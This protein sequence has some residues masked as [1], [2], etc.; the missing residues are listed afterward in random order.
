ML[1]E[2]IALILQF[3]AIDDTLLIPFYAVS[4]RYT[5]VFSPFLNFLPF[6]LAGAIL[7]LKKEIYFLFVH[8]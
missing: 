6:P 2:V 3:M 4:I 5:L 7:P 1:Y 8:E